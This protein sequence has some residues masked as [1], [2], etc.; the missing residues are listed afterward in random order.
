ME[1]ALGSTGINATADE[2]LT[3][4]RK[5]GTNE[6]TLSVT[7]RDVE[8]TS[9]SMTWDKD[10]CS[11]TISGQGA[12]KPVLTE[13]QQ[14]IVDLLE[15]E[16]RNWTTGKIAEQLAKNKTAVSNLLKRLQ[17]TGQ[18]ETPYYGQYRLKTSFTVSHTLKERESV[19]LPPGPQ[20]PPEG[21]IST[22]S[23][24]TEPDIW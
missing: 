20:K 10:V 6:A 17:E 9:Y 8:D 18:I 4:K 7:G 24:E 22:T 3:M 2:T 14:Q 1:S 19:K 13:A 23:T 12:L 15:S 16:A 5:R 21:T 11:W